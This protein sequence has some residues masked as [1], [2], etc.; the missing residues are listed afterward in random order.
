MLVV[1]DRGMYTLWIKEILVVSDAICKTYASYMHKLPI[2]H[3]SGLYVMCLFSQSCASDHSRVDGSVWPCL[4]VSGLVFWLSGP[5]L[6]VS[7]FVFE[8]SGLVNGCLDLYWGVWTCFGV[9]VYL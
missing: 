4:W 2:N 1:S 8:V 6:G 7:G 5:G 9:S 3:P